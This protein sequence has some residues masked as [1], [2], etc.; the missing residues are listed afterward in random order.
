MRQL[1]DAWNSW[2]KCN[3]SAPKSQVQ[4]PP[5]AGRAVHK[6]QDVV[7]Y[8][9]QISAYS[10]VAFFVPEKEKYSQDHMCVTKL[11]RPTSERSMPLPSC[12]SWSTIR[13]QPPAHTPTRFLGN[14]V[15]GYG[16][17]TTTAALGC[18]RIEHTL[19][20]WEWFG[21]TWLYLSL[22]DFFWVHG[23]KV[24]VALQIWKW[25]SFL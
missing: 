12:S 14:G 6:Q 22:S 21:S 19:S 16:M 20:F 1:E 9:V 5:F 3:F 8:T 11:L 2:T 17:D 24:R 15:T 7:L 23:I 4:A 13:W 18:G 25:V 10:G